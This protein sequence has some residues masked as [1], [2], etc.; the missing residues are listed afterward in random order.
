MFCGMRFSAFNNIMVENAITGLRFSLAAVCRCIPLLR[1]S[2]QKG[3][4]LCKPSLPDIVE[5]QIRRVGG[6]S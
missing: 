1:E 5:N 6:C 3:V 4:Q 2:L